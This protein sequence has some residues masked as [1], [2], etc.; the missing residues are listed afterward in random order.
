MLRE[1]MLCKFEIHH[2]PDKIPQTVEQLALPRTIMSTQNLPSSSATSDA[3]IKGEKY[4]PPF[5]NK[6][7]SYTKNYE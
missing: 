7:D 4:D 3:Y 2:Y 1:V 5:A 6:P